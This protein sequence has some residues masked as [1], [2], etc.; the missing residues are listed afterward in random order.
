LVEVENI[1]YACNELLLKTSLQERITVQNSIKLRCG[2][3]EIDITEVEGIYFMIEILCGVPAIS[4]G[5]VDR[6][7]TVQ[8]DAMEKF[9]AYRKLGLRNGTAKSFM[10]TH[11]KT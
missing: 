1:V 4:V 6:V 2:F 3:R 11:R 9:S 5:G 10:A 8:A 7:H